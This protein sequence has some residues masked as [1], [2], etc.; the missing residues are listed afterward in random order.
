MLSAHNDEPGSQLGH[1]LS[2]DDWRGAEA[3]RQLLEQSGG[4]VGTQGRDHLSSGL[5]PQG[6][7]RTVVVWWLERRQRI[8]GRVDQLATRRGMLRQYS[9]ERGSLGGRR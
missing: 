1:D 2:Q 6:T 5:L 9:G 8:A 4:H 3:D 7:P